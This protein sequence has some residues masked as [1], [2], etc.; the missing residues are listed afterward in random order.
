MP[1][2]KLLA[3]WSRH[4]NFHLIK[5]RDSFFDKLVEA[6][7]IF[8]KLLHEFEVLSKPNLIGHH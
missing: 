6:V 1:D 2:E 8:T 7:A 3:V 4:K 5:S